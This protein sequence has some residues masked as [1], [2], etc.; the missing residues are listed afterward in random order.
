MNQTVYEHNKAKE[1]NFES[2]IEKISV[3]FINSV[4]LSVSLSV[5][6]CLIFSPVLDDLQILNSE[7]R[8]S[9]HE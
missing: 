8:L 1:I 5:P 6:L 2:Q 7:S 9:E 4:L 3:E